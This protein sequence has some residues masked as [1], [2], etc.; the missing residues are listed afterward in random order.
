M[1]ITA[2]AVLPRQERSG[3]SFGGAALPFS[4]ARFARHEQLSLA[5]LTLIGSINARLL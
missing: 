1:P 3:V 2:A 5:G 4:P